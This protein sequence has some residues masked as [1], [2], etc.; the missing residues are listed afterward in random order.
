MLMRTLSTTTLLVTWIAAAS[1]STKDTPKGGG[2]GASCSDSSQCT[3][4]KNPTCLTD[5]KPIASVVLP[6]A[7]ASGDPFRNF[8][9][10]F[11]G[12]YCGNTV[13]ES[14]QTDADCGAGA[15]CF[16]P[17]EGVSQATIDGLKNY[18]LPFDAQEFASKG[19]CLKVCKADADC[20]AGEGYKCIV[21]VHALVKAF[22]GPTATNPTGYIKTFCIQDVETCSLLAG[23]G[24]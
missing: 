6:D 3:G 24:G 16:R 19:L 4:Y 15:G 10:P 18:Q 20:R 22:N 11:P 8:D 12:G 23:C 7:G 2:V 9:I 21:P 5:L 14:C 17:F 1:C 13:E